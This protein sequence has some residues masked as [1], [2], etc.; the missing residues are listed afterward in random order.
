MS[1]LFSFKRY[2]YYSANFNYTTPSLIF[3]MGIFMYG[4]YFKIYKLNNIY[5]I[6]LKLNALQMAFIIIDIIVS[7][8]Q[9]HIHYSQTGVS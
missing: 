6:L 8:E 9:Q 2:I 5:Y 1:P 7:L 3:V 4:V